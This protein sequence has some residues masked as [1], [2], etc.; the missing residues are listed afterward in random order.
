MSNLITCGFLLFKWQWKS[1]INE[2]MT[3][4]HVY[5]TLTHRTERRSR[6]SSGCYS[7]VDYSFLFHFP[8]RKKKRR[9]F[10][11]VWQ[12]LT[13][14]R[15]LEIQTPH[16]QLQ[17]PFVIVTGIWEMCWLLH[18][19]PGITTSTSLSFLF[20]SFYLFRAPISLS[21]SLFH[22][23]VDGFHALFNWLEF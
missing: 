15:S 22:Q 5:G 17:L 8:L 13:A 9:A 20:L 21:C 10:R 7:K 14:R 18:L 12:F 6:R 16:S 3:A 4:C 11:F 2:T 19:Y 23:I 1:K